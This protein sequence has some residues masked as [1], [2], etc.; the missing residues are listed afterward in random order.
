[1][2]LPNLARLHY[3]TTAGLLGMFKDYSVE[4][5]DIKLW[6]THYMY[7]NDPQ[8]Y[9]LGEEVCTNIIE[10]LEQELN[11]PLEYR[12]K[13]LVHSPNYREALDDYCKTSDG[14]L[15][16]PYIISFSKVFDSLHMWDMYASNGNGLA[17]VFNY[18]K[19]LEKGILLKDCFYCN[20]FCKNVVRCITDKYKIDITKIYQ[21]I[22]VQF[23]L[24]DVKHNFENGDKGLYYQ[25]IYT[26][27]TL[28][29]GNIGIR[30]KNS[31]YNIEDEARI[32][33]Y[34]KNDYKILFR[35]RK[36][37]I[38]P[39]IEYPIPFDCVENI[40]IGP[41]ADF[42]RVRESILIFLDYKGVKDWNKDKILQSNVPYRL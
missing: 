8:E 2:K 16:C 26:L 7:M 31:S 38:L 10:Q 15:V 18:Q 22:D 13:G 4:H 27:H 11:I 36:G 34:G 17:L 19:L 40:L 24:N 5:P 37:V 25:R 23:P 39:Y 41:T 21:E 28:I 42:N 29:C 30:I 14:Q 33:V 32:T 1:M 3:T 20:P 12:V 6:A 9:V 35:D